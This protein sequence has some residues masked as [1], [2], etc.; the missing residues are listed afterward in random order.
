MH[1]AQYARLMIPKMENIFI[2][3]KIASKRFV[4]I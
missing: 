3:E 4:K 2:G 1:G